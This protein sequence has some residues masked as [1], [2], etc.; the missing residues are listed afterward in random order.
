[1]LSLYIFDRENQHPNIPIVKLSAAQQPPEKLFK[2]F[3]SLLVEMR[4]NPYRFYARLEAQCDVTTR[5]TDKKTFSI[6]HNFAKAL[7]FFHEE[8]TDKN[9][10]LKLFGSFCAMVTSEG[11]TVDD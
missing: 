7:L 3:K 11:A 1:M 8:S 4:K 10:Y 2:Y 9:E 5:M 6:M